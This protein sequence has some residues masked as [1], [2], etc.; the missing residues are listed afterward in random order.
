M[1]SDYGSVVNSLDD[2]VVIAIRQCNSIAIARLYLWLSHIYNLQGNKTNYAKYL[3]LSAE[4]G[5]PQAQY[6]IGLGLVEKD[7]TLALDYLLKSA[8]QEVR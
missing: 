1:P 8:E 6:E 2:L 5:H 4:L 3:N 7:L